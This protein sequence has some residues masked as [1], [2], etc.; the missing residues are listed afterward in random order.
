M[1]LPAMYKVRQRFDQP[2]VE[3]L[4]TAVH[5]EIDRLGLGE[6]RPGTTVGVAGGSRGIATSPG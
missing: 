4:E 2:A 1:K 5:Q 6:L 3:D